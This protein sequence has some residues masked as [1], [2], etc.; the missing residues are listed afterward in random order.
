MKKHL[1]NTLI[2]IIFGFTT[3]AQ[4]GTID[5]TFNNTDVGFGGDANNNIYSI[6]IQSDG[7][8]I[9]GGR[10]TSYNGVA[11]N[12]IA[13]LN[14]DGTLDTTFNQGTGV[15][16]GYNTI[17]CISIQSDGKIIIGGSFTSYNGVVRNGIAL[18]NTDG[19][20]DATF[21]PGTT[22]TET[23]NA[24]FINSISIQNDGK[25]II[26]GDFISYDGVSRNGIARLNIDGTL[27][28]AGNPGTG[29]TESNGGNSYSRI[30]STF[31]QSDGKVIIG[32]DFKFYNGVSRNGI[33]RLN[34][35]GTLDTTFNPGTGAAAVF[36]SSISAT[37]IQ[38][39]GKIIIG[40]LFTSYNGVTRN[41]IARLNTNGTLD[42]TFNPGTGVDSTINSTFIQSDGK[43]IICGD[44]KFYNGVS[45]NGIARLNTNGTLDTTFNPGTGATGTNS[46]TDIYSTSIQSDGKIIIGGDFEY[47]DS[48]VR[49]RIT[50][51]NNDGTL[52]ATFSPRTGADSNIVTT[53][54]QIDGKIIIGGPFTSYNGVP[55]SR[56]ARVN[57]DGTLD[58]TFNP[59]TGIGPANSTINC[60]SIATDGKII[61]GGSFYIYNGTGRNRIARLN[62]D[63]TLDTTFNPQIDETGGVIT[64]SSISIAT[65]GKIIIGGNFISYNG[66]SRN[67]IARL[68]TNG[69]L[70]TT[71]NPGT[72]ANT[73]IDR[74]FIQS[75]G[76]IIIAGLF[77]SY[78]GVPRNGIA[79]LNTDGT[80]DTSFNP[81][82]GANS[83]ISSISIQSDGKIIIGGSFTSY[84]G[85][86]I[87]R[88]ARLNTDGTLDT[89]FNPGTGTGT[90]SYIYST[91]I[92]SDGKIIIG[93]QFTAYNGIARNNIARLNA[94]G[95]L[96]TNFNPGIGAN[97]NIN[98]TSIQSDGKIIIGGLFTGYNGLGRNRI[99]RINGNNTLSNSWFDKSTIAIYP[100]PSNGIY[101][102]QANDMNA[103]K[104][105]SIYT[106]LGQKIFD[107]VISSNKTTIDISN[108]PKG[109]YLYKVFGEQEETKGGKL[110]VE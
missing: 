100:N 68:N 45:R 70:D 47:Y 110:I 15:I 76:K 71:F 36:N 86:V 108:Q 17:K 90:N 107:A 96:D 40:G 49:S 8:I 24:S 51:L 83:T 55:R 22:T 64:I 58:T 29:V 48:L 99:T 61:I 12:G 42:T 5:L 19:T 88:I 46:V 60:I 11:R 109:V 69:T 73:R 59:G 7:K 81:G 27:D 80:L 79:S 103:V 72:G 28:T 31:I 84:N 38:S 82:T 63:G 91:S 41:S 32:G 6:S 39:D 54:I 93:G 30:N 97:S 95:T 14:T 94:D 102:L 2:V 20:L 10:F 106:I 62:T 43:V 16:G 77:T 18:L 75:D 23:G 13:R 89:T 67:R 4:P 25:I 85:V 65:D 66:V 34:T 56:I 52:D 74:T 92:Q 44:F 101:T 50:R 105:I 35:D 104:S 33:A 3:Y 53:S 21:N 9:I 37:S 78:N 57:T 87:S 26:G 1:L 98:S